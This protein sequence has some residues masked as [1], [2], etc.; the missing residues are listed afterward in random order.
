MTF[1]IVFTS[2]Y[3]SNK[4][5]YATAVAVGTYVAG[6]TILSLLISALALAGVYD[7]FDE[8][9]AEV[10]GV[11]SY[12][13]LTQEQKE[14]FLNQSLDNY[15]M[16]MSN[17]TGLSLSDYMDPDMAGLIS[18]A[19]NDTDGTSALD[20]YETGLTGL[21]VAVD[22]SHRYSSGKE[23]DNNGK[24]PESLGV[25]AGY[26]NEIS[27]LMAEGFQKYLTAKYTNL[28]DFPSCIS[29]Y[30]HYR[31]L[32]GSGAEGEFNIF[33]DMYN[34]NTN[35][36]Y[37]AISDDDHIYHTGS[38]SLYETWFTSYRSYKLVDNDW[39]LLYEFSNTGVGKCDYL[40]KILYINHDLYFN[41]G[42]LYLKANPYEKDSNDN[43]PLYEPDTLA[44]D[45]LGLTY[46]PDVSTSL[47]NDDKYILT[48]N[49]IELLDNINKAYEQVQPAS[50]PDDDS[51]VN[52]KPVPLPSVMPDVL[53]NLSKDNY[54]KL[55]PVDQLDFDTNLNPSSESNPSENPDS[56]ADVPLISDDYTFY[57][58]ENVFPFCIPFDLIDLIGVLA[59]EPRAPSFEWVIPLSAIGADDYYITIDLSVF[60]NIAKIVRTMELLAGCVGLALLTRNIIRG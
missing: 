51:E 18:S 47:S 48:D 35:K 12:S 54:E 42:D 16:Y 57:G 34:L 53:E 44:N 49:P 38:C 45:V 27:R 30:T 46:Y 40:Y 58:L 56:G 2:V 15:K 31:V 25:T 52:P 37:G 32:W 4:K 59:A 50:N 8:E 60:D 11:T 39:E 9:D 29:N 1:I 26:I 22:N 14:E 43:Q 28:P 24:M 3:I 17:P 10:Y 55:D 6:E 7:A 33:L 36:F 19:V 41:N 13:E 20:V 5:A 21:E 23:P